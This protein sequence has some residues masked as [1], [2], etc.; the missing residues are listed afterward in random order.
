E[1]DGTVS[2]VECG[3]IRTSS[4][5]ALPARIREIF[6]EVREI[7]ERFEPGTVAVEDVFQG[8]NVRSA[9]TLGHARGAILLAAALQEV[10]IAE[11]TPGEIKKAVVGT[12]RASKDQVGFMVQKQLRLRSAP[13]PAD[14][15][16][17]VAAALC[18]CMAVRVA[19]P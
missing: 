1:G 9:L 5:E 2:L 17:G 19:A 3:V 10:E 18:H 7:I 11:Y 14:A 16:D 12:G 6:E 13:T 8:K 4:N 15:A